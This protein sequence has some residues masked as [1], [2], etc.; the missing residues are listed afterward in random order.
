MNIGLMGFEL[1]SANMG[2]EALSY[3]FIDFLNRHY[4]D[5][6]L[7][8]YVFDNALGDLPSYYSNIKFEYVP[9]KLRDIKCKFIQ[10]VIKCDLIFDVTMG[11]SFSD[12]YSVN[13]CL[14]LIKKKRCVE[15]FNHRYIL[16]PQTYGP[17]NND[18]VKK[19]A[20]TVINKANTVISR[21]KTSIEYLKSLN[22][23]RDIEEQ[24]DLAFMLPFD[25]EKY[26]FDNNKKHLGINVSGLLWKGGFNSNNQFGLTIDYK[27]FIRTLLKRYSNDEQWLI[28]LIPH[29][30]DLKDD[31]YDDDYSTLI[32]LH[33]EFP[34]TVLAPAFK[35]PIDAKSY[36]A[37]MDCFIGSRMHSTIAA[38]SSGIAV[39]PVSYSRK[40][41]GL[42]DTLDYSYLIHGRSYDTITAISKAIEYIDN[43]SELQ[44]RVN[45][46]KPAIDSKVESLKSAIRSKLNSI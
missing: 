30:I 7:V 14:G 21:D 22:V 26:S 35:D 10:S 11:D 38:I 37:N 1:K 40:F 32:M 34:N 45:E 18:E 13:Y 27:E 31:A 29:V 20:I 36:I 25:K 19:K 5:K 4:C 16:M 24:I 41:E 44:L 42:F 9:Y 6:E 33:N 43:H 12:I 23:S 15:L 17:F 39:I 8:I 46:I 2:C 3:A 28:H